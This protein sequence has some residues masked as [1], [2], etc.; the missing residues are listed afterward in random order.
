[1]SI[2]DWDCLLP[3]ELID[4]G[5]AFKC[6]GTVFVKKTSRTAYV[7]GMPHRWFYFSKTQRVWG[8]Q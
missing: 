2:Q 1:M 5:E 7:F 4:I 6:N 3:F 8:K